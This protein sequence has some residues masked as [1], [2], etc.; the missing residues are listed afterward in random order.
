MELLVVK[1][2]FFFFRQKPPGNRVIIGVNDMKRN[3][4]DEF[5]MGL[6]GVC[7][8]IGLVLFGYVFGQMLNPDIAM[9]MGEHTLFMPAIICLALSSVLLLIVTLNKPE[10]SEQG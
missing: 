8:T 1:R 2:F 10:I 5:L 7:G 3:S 4:M 9:S 6:C